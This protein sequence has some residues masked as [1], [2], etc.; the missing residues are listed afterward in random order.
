M[1]RLAI[2]WVFLWAFLDKMFGLG[3]ATPAAKAWINGGHP[4]QGFSH[5]PKG[6]ADFYHGIAGASW[7]DW[8]F[9]A[10]LAGIGI[11]LMLGIGVRI[12]AWT[13]ALLLM[14][15]WSALLPLENNPVLDDH[16]VYAIVLIGLAVTQAGNTVGLGRWWSATSLVRRYPV[17]K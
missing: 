12:A 10:G 17:L 14:M 13:G 1:V 3:F 2:G 4:T 8:L 15:M 11:A 6:F 16:V 9:M 7:A 5:R